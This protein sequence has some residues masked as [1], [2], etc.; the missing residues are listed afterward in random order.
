MANQN[1]NGQ[2]LLNGDPEGPSIG[3]VAFFRESPAEVT[4]Q[5]LLNL[6]VKEI[7][8]L[9]DAIPTIRNDI[10]METAV[11]SAMMSGSRCAK[12]VTNVRNLMTK[13]AIFAPTPWRLIFMCTTNKCELCHNERKYNKCN[14]VN[15]VNTW[16]G[17]LVCYRCIQNE[18]CR[19]ISRSWEYPRA[20]RAWHRESEE[21]LGQIER[22]GSQ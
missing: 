14:R 13:R 1:Q 19:E 4:N 7:R 9:G 10:S 2:M 16:Y 21:L 20:T 6:N 22:V 15:Q 17:V 3:A 12:S 18:R 8:N 5:I 11:K